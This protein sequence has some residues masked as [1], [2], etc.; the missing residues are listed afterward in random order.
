M[1][2]PKQSEN[3]HEVRKKVFPVLIFLVIFVGLILLY[4]GFF[5]F[6]VPE[7]RTYK[8]WMPILIGLA[9]LIDSINPCAFSVLFLT[10][11]FLFG[12]GRRRRDILWVGITYVFGI[13]L[14]YVFIGLGFLKVLSL[15]SIPNLMSKIGATAIIIFGLIGLINEFFPN[16]P[17]KLKIPK[18]AYGRIAILIEKATIPASFVLGVV[19]GL[20]EFPCTG[21]PYLFVLGLLHDQNNLFK[22]FVYL[23]FYNFMFVLPLLIALGIAVNKKVLDT[24]DNIRRAETKEARIWIALA[25][26]LLGSLVFMI[27]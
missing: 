13:F 3:S 25:M 9:A 18:F 19:V 8:G 26:I 17:L 23:I 1:L 2:E 14:A 24:M 27:N 11:T 12:L 7:I 20:F 5:Q 15:F 22:G 16:F 6:H 10:I 21:G 4:S